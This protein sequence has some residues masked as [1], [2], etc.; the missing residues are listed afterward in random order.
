MARKKRS[1]K[2]APPVVESLEEIESMAERIAQW[3]ADNVRIV[4]IS[5]VALLVSAGGIQMYR[6]HSV[7]VSH[8]ASNALA[9]TRDAY[10]T[11]MGANAGSQEIPELAKFETMQIWTFKPTIAPLDSEQQKR[12][13]EKFGTVA[14]PLHAVVTPDGRIIGRY[15]YKGATTTPEHYLKFLQ[16]SLKNFGR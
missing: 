15:R 13:K 16:R 6:S 9:K 10:F 8:E 12:M 14:I 3:I 7:T 4:V 11:A 2:H 5:I 1:S